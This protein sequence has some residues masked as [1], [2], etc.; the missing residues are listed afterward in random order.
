MTAFSEIDTA[1]E[2]IRG[3]G[4]YIVNPNSRVDA[5]VTKGSFPALMLAPVNFEAVYVQAK[6][7]AQ[8]KASQQQDS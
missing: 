8:E 4:S 2:S 5:L 7:N 6:R 3:W 1:I